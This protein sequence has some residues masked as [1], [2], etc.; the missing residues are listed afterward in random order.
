M[1]ELWGSNGVPFPTVED[2]E[3]GSEVGGPGVLWFRVH[4]V[5]Y[6]VFSSV[7]EPY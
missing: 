1:V 6:P 4:L 5:D 3:I 2:K 7:T